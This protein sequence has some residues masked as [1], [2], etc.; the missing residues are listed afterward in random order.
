MR[1]CWEEKSESVS[2]NISAA[3]QAIMAMLGAI[4]TSLHGLMPCVIREWDVGR[5]RYSM[6]C[7]LIFRGLQILYVWPDSL[8][9]QKHIWMRAA[10]GKNI[11][12]CPSLLSLSYL[13]SHISKQS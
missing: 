7:R 1:N 13:V 4:S 9:R 11:S 6:G 5:Y 3:M 10:F 8:G 2:G 12:C